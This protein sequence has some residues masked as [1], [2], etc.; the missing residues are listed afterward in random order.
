MRYWIFC[1]SDPALLKKQTNSYQQDSECLAVSWRLK[2]QHFLPP[3]DG[4]A[5]RTIL[6]YHTGGV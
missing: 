5:N 6:P 3:S 4:L 2:P 1:E